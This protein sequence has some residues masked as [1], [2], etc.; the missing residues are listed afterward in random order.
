M[1]VYILTVEHDSH[2]NA[3]FSVGFYTPTG[4]WV[5][6]DMNVSREEACRWVNYLNGGEGDAFP[7]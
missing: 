6:E 1:Y 4:K 7:S 3:L 5:A 2:G